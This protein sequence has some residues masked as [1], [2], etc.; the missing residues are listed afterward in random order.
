MKKLLDPVHPGEV[1]LEDF[2]KPLE[3]SQYRV[4][5]DIGVPPLRISEIVRGKRAVTAD[6]AMRLARYFA[7]TAGI[8]MRLQAQYDL[9]VAERAYGKEI[10]KNVAEL[11]TKG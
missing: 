1:L 6:T 3:L 8:W 11:S 2:M 4:A 10:D 7:T 9:E 5:T